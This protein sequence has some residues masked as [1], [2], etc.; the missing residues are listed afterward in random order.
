MAQETAKYTTKKIF[1]TPFGV[2]LTK[3]TIKARD[4]SPKTITI[5]IVK[6]LEKTYGIS[7]LLKAFKLLIESK[8]E[9][10]LK[11]LV[12][13]GGSQYK[14]LKKLA[15]ELSITKYVTFNGPANPDEIVNFHNLMDIEAYPSEQ[16]SFGVSAVEASACG[17]PVIVTNV[18]GLPEI[19][20]HDVS[21]IIVNKNDHTQLY[22][23]LHKLV[24]NDKLRSEM[25]KS[26]R[27]RVEQLYD[28]EKNLD[29]MIG[30]YKSVLQ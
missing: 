28:F 30:I 29:T 16:E 1:V 21:G 24:I 25:G 20:E 27:S 22:E 2:D 9:K 18:G 12:V 11:L 5:G 7:L 8:P 19:I 13:G 10:E 14:R 26:G 4:N 23:A 15:K 3:Y 17:N 6:S